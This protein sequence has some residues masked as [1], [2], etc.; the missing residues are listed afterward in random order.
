MVEISVELICIMIAH[1]ISKQL[2]ELFKI[3]E[4]NKAILHL[5]QFSENTTSIH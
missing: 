3:I 1:I 5:I 2:K 4:R